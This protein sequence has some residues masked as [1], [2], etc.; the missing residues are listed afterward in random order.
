M[1]FELPCSCASTELIMCLFLLCV[2][3]W[4]KMRM[5]IA[6]WCQRHAYGQRNCSQRN[7]ENT[8]FPLFS[9][10]LSLLGAHRAVNIHCSW[11][12]TLCWNEN[13]KIWKQLRGLGEEVKARRLLRFVPEKKAMLRPLE[14]DIWWAQK[15]RRRV[16][17]STPVFLSTSWTILHKMMVVT[18]TPFLRKKWTTH[19]KL[20]R[21][22]SCLQDKERGWP[23]CLALCFMD[24]RTLE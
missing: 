2:L 3:V 15:E 4:M 16:T 13:L 14:G 7:Y 21:R 24:N 17:G 23:V 19:W 9:K 20:E 1:D 5:A 6:S 18:S 10:R 22:W 11:E 8:K 12:V